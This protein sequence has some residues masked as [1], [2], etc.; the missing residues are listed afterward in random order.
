MGQE[1]PAP[2]QDTSFCP[3]VLGKGKL[4]FG[5][6]E[7]ALQSFMIWDFF[8]FFSICLWEWTSSFILS[9]E[10]RVCFLKIVL[11]FFFFLKT[12]L[13]WKLINGHFLTDSALVPF[14]K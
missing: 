14:Q 5:T 12:E 3:T 11:F 7:A 4:H 13:S 10:L 9:M 2:P 8:F 6:L 1:E